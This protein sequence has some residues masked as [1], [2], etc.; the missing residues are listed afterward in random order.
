MVRYLGFRAGLLL[1]TLEQQRRIYLL[2]PFLVGLA[3]FHACSAD[4]GVSE[5]RDTL[6][7][8]P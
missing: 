8:E 1:S 3:E 4:W 2:D 6:S 5:N 7:G